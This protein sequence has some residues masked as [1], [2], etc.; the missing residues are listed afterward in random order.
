MRGSGAA[1]A[2]AASAFA[3]PV[4]PPEAPEDEQPP[5][6]PEMDRIIRLL[7]DFRNAVIVTRVDPQIW[8]GQK[9]DVRCGTRWQCPVT[10]DRISDDVFGRFGGKRFNCVIIPNTPNGELK[11]LGG[12]SIENPDDD[13]PLK[14]GVPMRPHG[15]PPGQGHI[16]GVF[17]IPPTVTGDPTLRDND[18]PLALARAA[19]RRKI[20]MTNDKQELR[21]AQAAIRELDGAEAQPRVPDQRD[22]EL[23][24]L[25]AQ[26]DHIQRDREKTGVEDKWERRLDKLTE[27]VTKAVEPRKK[28]GGDEITTI[29]LA[30]LQSSDARFNTMMQS[31]TSS[32]Q[33]NAAGGRRQD[34]DAILDKLAKYK[35]LFGEGDSRSKKIEDMAYDFLMEK[36]SGGGAG[37]V[38]EEDTIQYAIKHLTPVLKTYVEKKL[39]QDGKGESLTP[40]QYK[41]MV[42]EEA[43]KQSRAI[44][45]DLQRKGYLIR[46]GAPGQKPPGLPAPK[47]GAGQKAGAPPPK[48]YPEEGTVT[49]VMIQPDPTKPP[50]PAESKPEE[51]PDMTK[52]VN[53]EGVGQV[54]IP[55]GPT[56]RAYQRPVAVNFVLDAIASEVIQ[57][58]PQDRPDD[59]LAAGDMLDRLDDEL[60]EGLSK[61]NT[62]ADLEKLLGDAGGMPEKIERIKQ[63]GRE[64]ALV[65]TWLNRVIATVQEEFQRSLSEPE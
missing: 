62:G 27:L 41:K 8:F 25:R 18:S 54:E 63:L 23:R 65:K 28:E 9:I 46:A 49:T 21:E 16:P 2:K 14:D 30:Q 26:L 53:L 64:D 13:E 3:N 12:F 52:S 1:V 59:S 55:A 33:G 19:I 39:E 45:E 37:P 47:A 34:E 58:I 6:D 17:N 43:A 29:L 22:E 40:E 5:A 20:Q 38:E 32:L 11:Q 50:A 57:R 4:K 51:K 60:L 61:I 24:A 10:I 36:M 42:H 44:V 48:S 31:F 7:S 35:T 56:S 15:M